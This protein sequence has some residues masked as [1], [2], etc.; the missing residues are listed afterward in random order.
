MKQKPISEKNKKRLTEL[1]C[2]LYELRFSEGLTQKQVCQELDLH[3][4]TIVRIEN[5]K[6][7]KISS[8]FELIDFYD[9]TPA[10]IFQD[11]K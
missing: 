5:S 3:P 1:G 7:F 11:I 8:L 4:N 9:I 6:N 10:E 2:Y